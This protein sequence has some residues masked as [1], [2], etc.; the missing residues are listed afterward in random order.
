MK[1]RLLTL[2]VMGITLTSWLLLAWAV[3]AAEPRKKIALKGA[4]PWGESHRNSIGLT[5]FAKRLGELSNGDISMKIFYAGSI[6]K[7]PTEIDSLK[8]GIVDVGTITLPYHAGAIPEYVR[9]AI[10]VPFVI[11]FDSWLWLEKNTDWYKKYLK[12]LG[13]HPLYNAH[14]E[15]VITLVNPMED[16]MNPSLKGRKIRAPGLGFKELINQLGGDT[17][18]MPSAEA[19][20][21]LATGLVAGLYTT[22]DTWEAEGLATVCPQVYILNTPFMSP[23]CM[24]DSGY[25]KLPEWARKIVDQA[26]DETAKHM[27][28]WARNYRQTLLEKYKGHPKVRLIILNDEQMT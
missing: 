20:A 8:K 26:G 19:P 24:S 9:I 14:A 7:G 3:E 28:D 10:M 11:D 1:K 22:L 5:Y 12:T 17:V 27:I 16:V 2:F 23:H 18:T 4:S 21:A 25:K 13:L 6:V 15:L